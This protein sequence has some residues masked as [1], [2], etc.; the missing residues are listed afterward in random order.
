MLGIQVLFT[1]L[2]LMNRVFHSAPLTLG[3]WTRIAAAAAAIF[4]IV[5]FETWLRFGGARGRNR[6]PE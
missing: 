5:E 1:H 4:L 3:A 6:I 2:P